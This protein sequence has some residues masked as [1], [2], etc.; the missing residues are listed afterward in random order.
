[1]QVSSQ[2][3]TYY[4]VLQ[5]SVGLVFFVFSLCLQFSHRL[6][7]ICSSN[8]FRLELLHTILFSSV[9]I[10]VFLVFGLTYDNVQLFRFLICRH[11]KEN[12]EN[13]KEEVHCVFILYST[14]K[15]R[16]TLTNHLKSFL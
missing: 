1:M 11:R 6:V 7:N 3:K 9:G 8:S 5:T 13:A 15:H 4:Y 2:F 10:F 14:P 12:E 16:K